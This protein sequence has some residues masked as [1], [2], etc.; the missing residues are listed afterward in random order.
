MEIISQKQIEFI[1]KE[2]IFFSKIINIKK[3]KTK[4]KQFLFFFSRKKLGFLFFLIFFFNYFIFSY[5]LR[6]FY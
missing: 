5:F 2:G 1:E 6:I 3:N 4:I